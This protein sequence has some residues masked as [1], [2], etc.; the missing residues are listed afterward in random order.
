MLCVLNIMFLKGRFLYITL[1]CI[2][3][4]YFTFIRIL[5]MVVITVFGSRRL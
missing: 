1:L 5:N 4:S 2:L 3:A